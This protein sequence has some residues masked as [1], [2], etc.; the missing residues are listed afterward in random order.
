MF[1][2]YTG[3]I[4]GNK[5]PEEEKIKFYA[6]VQGSLSLAYMIL[7]G[8]SACAYCYNKKSRFIIS[9]FGSCNIIFLC[10]LA[11]W[12]IIGSV[13]VWK[14][15]DEWEND[16][17]VCNGA[18]FIS[19]MISLSFHYILIMLLCCCFCFCCVSIAHKLCGSN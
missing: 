6:I 17:S 3:I 12:A 2:I 4:V 13:W 5:C 16:H 15:L 8:L 7:C 19:A 14:I 18:L 11:I 1:V 9:L 10:L